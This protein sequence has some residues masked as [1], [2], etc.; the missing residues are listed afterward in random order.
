MVRTPAYALT[1]AAVAA[2]VAVFLGWREAVSPGYLAAIWA[3]D[4]GGRFASALVV[5]KPRSFYL[6]LLWAGYF[7]ATPLLVLAPLAWVAAPHRQRVL[8]S[9]SLCIVACVL[10][11]FSCAASKLD[12]YILTALPFMA[13]AA[14]VTARVVLQQARAALASEAPLKATVLMLVATVPLL[15]GGAGAVAR[16]YYL[17]PVD[18]GAA[19]GR[20]G[21][22]FDAIAPR[23]GSPILV[24]DPG[25]LSDGRPHY[26]PTLLAYR[27]LWQAR[28]LRI[29][30]RY[31]LDPA[32][33]ARPTVLASCSPATVARLRRLGRDEAGVEGCAAMVYPPLARFMAAAGR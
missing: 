14:A 24:V 20:Y 13:I 15:M 22:L 4:L 23:A 6:G 25:F 29:A 12:H 31:D 18:K 28:G 17:P 10:V 32:A 16:R 26:A 30:H 33:P 2:V 27:E 11:T 3:N 7:A 8:L 9:Y 19:A 1:G 5:P 21:A